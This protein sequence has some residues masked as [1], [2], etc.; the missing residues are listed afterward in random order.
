MEDGGGKLE[1]E[2]ETDTG[3]QLV[4]LALPAVVTADLRLNE[5][6][7]ATLPNIMKVGASCCRTDRVG[8]KGDETCTSA[9]HCP[10]LLDC[11]TT[12]GVVGGCALLGTA[13]LR[14]SFSVSSVLFVGELGGMEYRHSFCSA[15]VFRQ[16]R[17][18]A[19][20]SLWA[21]RW[22]LVFCCLFFSET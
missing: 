22:I 14:C 10:L 4:S 1:V 7:Y 8:R 5:P 6:R 12:S 20:C 16:C 3:T 15:Q 17:G 13:Y 9:L 2:R 11:C 18:L 19:V 21:V